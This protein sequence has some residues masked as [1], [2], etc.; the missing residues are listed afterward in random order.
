MNY[1]Y[2][3]FDADDTLLDY[4][5]SEVVALENLLAQHGRRCPAHAKAAFT[6]LCNSLW[7]EYGLNNTADSYFSSHYHHLYYEYSLR[8]FEIFAASFSLG[9]PAR[10]LSEQYIEELSKCSFLTEGAFEICRRLSCVCKLFVITNGLWQMQKNRFERSQIGHY[11]SGL[12]VSENARFAMPDQRFFE[13]AMRQSEIQDKS[14]AL[15][16]GD[17][18]ANDIYGGAQYGIDTCWLNKNGGKP[19]GVLPTYRISSLYELA[20][21]VR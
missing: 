11:I 18:L 2:I 21:I 3:L 14:A 16:V 19:S 15:V 12:I 7:E 8:R 5:K 13:Y 10:Q 20:R 1:R 4:A 17:S 9:L 6:G